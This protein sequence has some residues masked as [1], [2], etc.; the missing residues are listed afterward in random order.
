MSD[1]VPIK[2][3]PSEPLNLPEIL[4]GT[5]TPDIR[6][7][8]GKSS[9]QSRIFLKPGSIVVRVFIRGAHTVRT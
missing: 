1:L 7:R 5:T 9:H 3:I 4:A 2:S 8:V 6:H